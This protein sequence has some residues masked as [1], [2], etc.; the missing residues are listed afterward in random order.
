[1]FRKRRNE[2][3]LSFNAV[4]RFL[5]KRFDEIGFTDIE[6]I[7][8]FDNRMRVKYPHVFFLESGL[9]INPEYENYGLTLKKVE[10]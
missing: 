9:I 4:F 6:E 2:R 3:D 10:K 7:K 1:M 5:L 8:K